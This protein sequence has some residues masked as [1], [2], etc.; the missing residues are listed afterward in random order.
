MAYATDRD[1][2]LA[3]FALS[4]QVY[5]VPLTGERGRAGR[6]HADPGA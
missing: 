6:G 5:T 2:T 4:G 3:A 1:V